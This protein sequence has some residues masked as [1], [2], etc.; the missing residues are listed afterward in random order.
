MST[1][2]SALADDVRGSWASVAPK[3]QNAGVLL[4]L[5]AGAAVLGVAFMFVAAAFDGAAP[6]VALAIPVVPLLSLAVLARPFVGVLVVIA[7]LPFGSLGFAAAGTTLQIVEVA[8]FVVAALVVIRRLAASQTPLPWTPIF[9]FPL[10]L[11]A[12]TFVALYSAIDETLAVKQLFALAGGTLLASVVLAACRSML[13]VRRVM[14][15]LVAAAALMSILAL[16]TGGGR[17]ASSYGGA[18]VTGRLSGAFE[19]PN[20]LGSFCAMTAALAVGLAA[21]ARS[22]RARVASGLALV[23][24]LIAL[25]L[26]F[27]RGAWI[28]TAAAFVFLLIMLR[29]ARR[30]LFAFAVP[31]AVLGLVIWSAEPDSPQLEVVGER[32]RAITERSPYDGRDQIWAEAV[33]QVADDPIT[34]QGPGSFPVASVRAASEAFS[35]APN[36]AHNLLLNWAAETGIPAALVIVGFAV[37]LGVATRGASLGALARGQPRDRAIVL[38]IAA[39]LISVAGQGFFD[40]VL[41]NAVLHLTVWILIGCLVVAARSGGSRSPAVGRSL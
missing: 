12:W 38:A 23:L 27:S 39:A 3:M 4:A 34:G 11:I 6:V 32:A 15:M 19:H 36:H 28:G 8:A 21:G 35:V 5:A 18:T 7:T 17:I 33:R 22:Q 13:D 37:A 10:A 9:F 40:Y 41:G 25:A 30:M 20:Q 2:P 16:S 29:D 14:G 31:L 26:T 1:R 24:L